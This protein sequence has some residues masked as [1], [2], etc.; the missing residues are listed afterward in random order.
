MRCSKCSS[1]AI[2]LHSYDRD[3]QR[4]DLCDVH[5]WK[6][7]H[8]KAAD[9]ITR[10]RAELAARDWQPIETAPRDGTVILIRTKKKKMRTKKKKMYEN[11]ECGFEEYLN[12]FGEYHVVKWSKDFSMMPYWKREKFKR[13]GGSWL[14]V[15][16]G[17]FVNLDK[18][19]PVT[20]RKFVDLKG[21]TENGYHQ[22]S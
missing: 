22:A 20:W 4:P 8:D 10:L 3:D 16:V 15:S 1:W 19:T 5:Y 7:R 17:S 2:N 14:S 9:E 13:E 11:L 21:T 6:W 12:Q 18:I